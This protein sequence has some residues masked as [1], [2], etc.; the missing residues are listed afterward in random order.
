[1]E[2]ICKQ[3][4]GTVKYLTAGLAVVLLV[5][6][7]G[8]FGGGAGGPALLGQLPQ[9]YHM[10]V[11]FDPEAM[12]LEGI[13]ETLEGNLPE[14][15][16]ENAEDSDIVIDPFSWADWKEGMGLR[17]GEIGIV[18]LTEDEELVAIFLP[19]TDQAKLE[20]FVEENDFGETEFIPYGEYTVMVIACDDDGLIEDLEYALTQA[21]LSS[22]DGFTAM[23][24]A[25]ELNGSCISFM[26]SGD[27]AEVPVYGVFSSNSTESILK[28]TVIT[29][30]NEVAQYTELFGDGLQSGNIRFP[31]NTIAAVRIT[32][33]MD[34]AQDMYTDVSGESGM[35]EIEAALPFIGFESMDEFLGVF[36]GDFCVSLQNMELDEHGEPDN[37]EG[38]F[39]I[40]LANPEKLEASLS[41]I[42]AFVEADRD[43][44]QGVDVWEMVN[45]GESFWYFIKDGVLYVS[46]NISPADVIDGSSAGDYFNGAASEGFLGGAV[47]PEGVMEGIHT[48]D[49]I[50]ETI[51]TLFENRAVFSVS[52]EDQMFT[53]TTVAGP[54]VLKSLL[55][56][57]T[58]SGAYQDIPELDIN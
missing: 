31:E 12:D 57:I 3:R 50:K 26:F 55:S 39:A 32:V 7:T 21:P 4:R 28:V 54:D 6:A 15:V 45:G 9:G 48:D 10:Y 47:D 41:V 24:E 34:K 16:L 17:D 40:S 49:E 56:L 37:M 11:A 8:C 35:A 43:E 2:G 38:V 22:D 44:I 25:T 5:S 13:L 18:A 29:D 46:M 42:S 23:K 27:V 53:A 52:R 51:T 33:D 20:D 30:G 19:C 1:L 14:D 58:L 36:Q